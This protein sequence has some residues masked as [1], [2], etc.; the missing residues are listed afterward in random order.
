[1]LKMERIDNRERF[2]YHFIPIWDVVLWVDTQNKDNDS[3]TTET[4]FAQ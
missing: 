4:C 3:N 2:K 1:M